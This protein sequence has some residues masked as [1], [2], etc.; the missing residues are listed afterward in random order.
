LKVWVV[1]LALLVAGGAGASAGC[2]G[3]RHSSSRIL[4]QLQPEPCELDLDLNMG[5]MSLAA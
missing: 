5:M 3:Q 4:D 2:G 1:Q